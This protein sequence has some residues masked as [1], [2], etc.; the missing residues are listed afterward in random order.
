M[1]IH[2]IIRSYYKQLYTSKSEELE[3]MYRFFLYNLPKLNHEAITNL[4]STI[5]RTD[6]ESVIKFLSTKKSPGPDGCT[7][8]FYQMYQKE[9]TPIFHKPFQIER[10]AILPNSFYEANT[11]LIQKPDETQ[12]SATHQYP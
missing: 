12:K 4:N 3:E 11:T 10:E 5:T 9:H 8:E 2:R 6:T 7:A 1:D